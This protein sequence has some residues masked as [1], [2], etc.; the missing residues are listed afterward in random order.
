M[1]EETSSKRTISDKGKKPLE[2]ESTQGVKNNQKTNPISSEG[3]SAPCGSNN[4][5]I[6]L[7]DM[8]LGKLEV[9]IFKGEVEKNVDGWLHQVERYFVV[10]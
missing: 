6:P 7:F 2:T 9:Q 8:R 3:V 10:N 1:R 5:E 4:R